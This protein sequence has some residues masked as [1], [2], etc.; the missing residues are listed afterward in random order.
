MTSPRR[1]SRR[2]DRALAIGLLVLIVGGPAGCGGQ[3]P[4]VGVSDPAV[5]T[6][7][8]IRAAQ[9]A[10]RADR[11]VD[12]AALELSPFGNLQRYFASKTAGWPQQQ[13]RMDEMLDQT[14][15]FE[16]FARVLAQALSVK[17]AVSEGVTVPTSNS[18]SPQSDPTSITDPDLK[19]LAAV[20]SSTPNDSPFDRLERA[21]SFYTS[22]VLALLRLYRTDARVVSVNLLDPIAT[23]EA[24]PDLEA[25]DDGTDV[26][27]LIDRA[28]KESA[29]PADQLRARLAELRGLMRAARHAADAWGPALDVAHR[30]LSRTLGELAK[31]RTKLAQALDGQRAD[32]AATEAG[33]KAA[34]DAV[35]QAKKVVAEKQ[36]EYDTA[37]GTLQRLIADRDRTAADIGRIQEEINATERELDAA[38][39]GPVI[40]HAHAAVESEA[41]QALADAPRRQVLVVLQVHVEPGNE[42]DRVVGLEVEIANGVEKGVAVLFAHPGRLYD[43]SDQMMLNRVQ[44]ALSVAVAAGPGNANVDAAGD[45]RKREEARGRYL[46]RLNKTASF[47]TAGTATAQPRFGWFFYPS[48]V[49]VEKRWL[50]G[51]Q[52]R[53]YLEAGGRDCAVWLSLPCDAGA[54]TVLQFKLTPVHGS[55]RSGGYTSQRS[56]AV[57]VPV[58]VPKY[59]RLEHAAGHYVVS[60]PVPTL[61]PPSARSALPAPNPALL[62]G[63]GGVAGRPGGTVMAPDK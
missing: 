36:A 31:A 11:G 42:A 59:S 14:Q 17:A 24:H 2:V 38:I 29:T 13:L 57:T 39:W 47:V 54:P 34:Q 26:R 53:G 32:P 30:E 61:A 44:Q 37:S 20:L 27:H 8:H 23:I 15:Q 49:V 41:F 16:S 6:M 1:Q 60:A 50:R 12:S 22:Y 55:I 21:R 28:R 9:Q 4:S 63:P 35:D 40:R 43:T 10:Y 25:R 45:S 3:H 48:N 52:A 18:A 46:A 51:Y 58:T 5:F 7:P 56:R 19:A 62:G 33:K